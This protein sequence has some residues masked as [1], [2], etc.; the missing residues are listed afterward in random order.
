MST[1]KALGTIVRIFVWRKMIACLGQPLWGSFEC[2]GMWPLVE[3]ALLGLAGGD[4]YT[5]KC[6]QSIREDVEVGHHRPR[7]TR[8]RGYSDRRRVER[9]QLNT[10]AHIRNYISFKFTLNHWGAQT[11]WS[12]I[13]A[14]ELIRL[15]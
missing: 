5:G 13:L 9:V 6:M 1:E 3:D 4:G 8:L 2:G 11:V 15:D 14:L 12:H 7:W 10:T